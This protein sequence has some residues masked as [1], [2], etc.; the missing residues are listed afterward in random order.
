MWSKIEYREFW[1]VPRLFIVRHNSRI[2]LFNSR[3]DDELDDYP[4]FYKVYLL[5]EIDAEAKNWETTI[6]DSTPFLG[7]V[8]I[9]DIKFDATR[10]REIDSAVLA[11]FKNPE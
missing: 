2:Y 7:E 8:K 6:T 4:D 9:E 5:Q 3:F 1:D 11:R 10:R